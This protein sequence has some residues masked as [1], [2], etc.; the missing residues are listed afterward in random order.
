MCC[1]GKGSQTDV[2]SPLPVLIAN[3]VQLFCFDRVSAEHGPYIIDLRFIAEVA[4]RIYFRSDR[5]ERHRSPAE[6]LKVV[7]FLR[8]VLHLRLSRIAYKISKQKNGKP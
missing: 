8:P 5:E 2:D 4:V 6:L 3:F 7:H 1:P